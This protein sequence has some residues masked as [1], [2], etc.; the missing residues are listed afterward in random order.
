M[1]SSF[2]TEFTVLLFAAIV[3][4]VAI[5]PYSIR[6]LK[7]SPKNKKLSMP[8]WILILLS[9]IQ[10]GILFAIAIS[11][12]LVLSHQ[13]GH[14]A[15]VIEA[16]SNG[17]N[18]SHTMIMNL[19][20]ASALGIGSG[21]FLL[22]A[23]LFFLPHFPKKLLETSLQTTYG[24][25]LMASFYGGINEEL[26]MRL[27]GVSLVIWLLSKISSPSVS[28]FWIANVFMALFF[29]VGHLP[30]LKTAIGKISSVMLLRTILL[31]TP[32]GLVCGWV[33]W[34]YGIEAAILTHFTADIVYH[35]GGTAVLRS[36]Y[37]VG[38]S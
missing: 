27:C 17:K 5:L 37:K 28:I 25:N 12:G 18:V 3:G 4:S 22:I 13:M 14:G 33:F 34:Q 8:R 1:F 6:L 31:N 2:W 30:A 26:F 19:L 29:A 36:R 16:V 20:S 15:P 35:V 32:I 9:I 11:I 24:E 23:D 21:G 10:N 7:A 38:T